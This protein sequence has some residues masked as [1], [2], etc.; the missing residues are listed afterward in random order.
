MSH[1]VI[2]IIIGAA[3]GFVSSIGVIIAERLIDKSGK[4]KVYYKFILSRTS[5]NRPWGVYYDN[6]RLMLEIPAVFELQ[7]TTN[8]TRV[9]RYIAIYLYKGNTRVAKMIQVES[10]EVIHRKGGEVT[11][12]D[13]FEYGNEKGSYSFVLPPRS[14]QRQECEFMLSIDLKDEEAND[15]DSLKIGYYDEGDTFKLFNEKKMED[16]WDVISYEPDKDWILLK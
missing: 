1:D 8:I 4:L 10:L 16:A 5:R 14:I 12:K 11:G 7:N 3:I 13:Q 15:F 6:N 9:I 2:L